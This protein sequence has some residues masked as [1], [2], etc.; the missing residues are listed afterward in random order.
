MGIGNLIQD[1]W[2]IYEF[3]GEV[4]QEYIRQMFKDK[5]IPEKYRKKRTS[6]ACALLK[7]L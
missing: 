6:L 7:I 2:I 3:E 4:A 1:I 5:I